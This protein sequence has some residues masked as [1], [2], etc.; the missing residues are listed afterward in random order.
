MSL[1][2]WL[3]AGQPA[4]QHWLTSVVSS[5]D[6]HYTWYDIPGVQD[7]DLGGQIP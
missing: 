2:L 5:N 4:S 1:Q 6:R 7:L 3:L